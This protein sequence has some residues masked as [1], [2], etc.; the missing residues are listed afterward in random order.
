MN[1]P[2]PPGLRY[3]PFQEQGIRFAI[4]HPKCL[5]AD[6]MGLGKTVQAIGLCNALSKIRNILV[7]CPA[8]MKLTWLREFQHWYVYETRRIA[9]ADGAAFPSRVDV[10]I[11]NYDL[12]ARHSEELH[13]WR[14]DLLIC[15][16]SHK[17]KN[18][19][20]QRTQHLLGNWVWNHEWR[21]WTFPTIR[22]VEADRILFL[23]GTPLLNRPAEPWTTARTLNPDGLGRS[24]S[25]L[26][27]VT[28]M[29]AGATTAG[30]SQARPISK[31]FPGECLGSPSVAPRLRYCPSFQPNGCKS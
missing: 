20:A 18:D 8:S 7:V 23:T 12:V 5:I 6:E 14:W 30:T 17:L 10:V 16:E 25:I 21:R 4:E 27:S 26:R 3:F 28:A 19:K 2:A 1:I 13:R 22:P 11:I 9:V 15:D 24:K 29:Q 31:S